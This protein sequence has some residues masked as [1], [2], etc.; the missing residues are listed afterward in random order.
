MSG[1]SYLNHEEVVIGG[2]NEG[3]EM[4]VST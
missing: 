4:G 3:M 2:T 1:N